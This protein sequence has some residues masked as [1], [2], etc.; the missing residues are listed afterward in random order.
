MMK[1]MTT[2]RL[3]AAA[4]GLGRASEVRAASTRIWCF[5]KA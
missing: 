4:A 5:E 1:M 3:V 2:I